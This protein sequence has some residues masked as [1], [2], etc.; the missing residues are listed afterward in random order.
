LVLLYEI[1]HDARSHI[2]HDA[3]SHE[4]QI[5]HSMFGNNLQ[6]CFLNQFE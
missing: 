4:R 3:R 1:Y 5:M 6:N 2:Y